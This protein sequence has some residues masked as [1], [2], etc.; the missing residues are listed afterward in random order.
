MPG[1]VWVPVA[2]L[3]ELAAVGCEV[4]EGLAGV[5]PKRVGVRPAGTVAGCR[6]AAGRWGAG[7]AAALALQ[8]VR[9]TNARVRSFENEL[10]MGASSRC[11]KR[12]QLSPRAIPKSPTVRKTLT[13]SDRG[14][15]PGEA[16]RSFTMP[17]ISYVLSA[18]ALCTTWA[19]VGCSDDPTPGGVTA[20]SP[21]V[22]GSSTSAAGSGGS[23]GSSGSTAVSGGSNGG[24]GGGGTSATGGAGTGGTAGASGGSAGAGGSGGVATGGAGGSAG[25]DAGGTAGT[26]GSDGP[27]VS[28]GNFTCT[29]D[30]CVNKCTAG[31][32]ESSCTGSKCRSR[33]E[34]TGDCKYTCGMADGADNADCAFN[35]VGG[36]CEVTCQGNANCTGDCPGGN[37]VYNCLDNANCSFSCVG[38][39]CTYNCMT[40]PLAGT[41]NHP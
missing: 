40:D 41:C 26:G 12:K 30:E 1:T 25:T 4:A 27:P 3:G 37:C 6:I 9:A 10:L 20:G 32:C 36:G 39:G 8:P 29:T 35:C 13:R 23:A 17:R 5:A 19:V 7:A 24:T 22:G 15:H 16:M 18:A 31:G 33:C 28:E 38:N 11:F 21:G 34:G 2:R 14:G